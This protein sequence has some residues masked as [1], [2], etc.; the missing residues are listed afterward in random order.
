VRRCLTRGVALL[1]LAVEEVGPHAG[2]AAPAAPPLP[3]VLPLVLPSPL[4]PVLLLVL[5]LLLP[6]LLLS[7]LALSHH[8]SRPPGSYHALT[9]GFWTHL[10]LSSP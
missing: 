8:L 3:L 5:P 7:W 1:A 10:P 2:H 4:P 6:A 9:S